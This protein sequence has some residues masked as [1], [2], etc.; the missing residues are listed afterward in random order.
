M[1]ILAVFCIFLVFAVAASAQ[2]SKQL[3]QQM[4]ERYE[5][6]WPKNFTFS[7]TT[8]MYRNDTLLR[9]E[10]WHEYIHYPTDFRI[11]FGHPDSGRAVI[12]HNDSSFAFRHGKMVAARPDE[13]D[14]IFL[15]GGMYFYPMDS[16]IAKMKSYG[17]NLDKFHE[18]K[19]K[20]NPVYVI[21]AAKGDET[22]NQLWIDKE[23]FNLLRMITFTN[24]RKQEALFDNHIKIGGGFSETLVHFFIN[25]KLV[26]VEKYFN[27]QA[28]KE[29][30]PAL[31]D[32]HHFSRSKN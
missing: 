6:K 18:D 8:E 16:V 32:P 5:G 12:Y 14:L 2:G 30:S 22:V 21:G 13:N 27:L 25:D 1:K 26:Q 3:L 15:L 20:G 28:D 23:N 24:G 11:D 9:T 7:Q 17:Y 19:W 10:T 29:I 31:F 4:H